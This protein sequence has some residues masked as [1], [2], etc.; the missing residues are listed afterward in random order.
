MALIT[1]ANQTVPAT[2][3]S[4]NTTLYTETT[5]KKLTTIADDGVARLVQP[6][7][8]AN[9]AQQSI[10][11]SDTY[12]TNSNISIPPSLLRAGAMFQWTFGMTRSGAGTA[13]LNGSAMIQNLTGAGRFATSA[14]AD[15]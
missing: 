6:L 9:T 7:Y 4:G 12:I 13:T 14:A 15:R 10:A 11:T 2:P 8:N 5:T 1:L 3:S